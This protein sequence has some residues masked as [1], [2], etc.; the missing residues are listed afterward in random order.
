[1]PSWGEEKAHSRLL[2]GAVR[3]S[4]KQLDSG[5][6]RRPLR[7]GVAQPL[8]LNDETLKRNFIKRREILNR[9]QRRAFLSTFYHSDGSLAITRSSGDFNLLESPAFPQRSEDLAKCLLKR[10]G[11]RF[12][13]IGHAS[14]FK[15]DA[16]S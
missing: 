12:R 11:C 6:R 9:S 7:G 5:V 13:R 10:G 16:T 8:R 15:I 3:H 2:T 4:S 1:V 14:I